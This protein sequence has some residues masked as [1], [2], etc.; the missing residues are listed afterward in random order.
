M[1]LEFEYVMHCEKLQRSRKN[2]AKLRI[3]TV[4]QGQLSESLLS[5]PLWR[6][7]LFVLRHRLATPGLVWLDMV[8]VVDVVVVVSSS[9]PQVESP[10]HK[11]MP[12]SPLQ[13]DFYSSFVFQVCQLLQMKF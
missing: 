6:P 5:R 3:L 13:R 4:G 8:V 9:L 1:G 11:L 10:S 12:P 2:A 7:F